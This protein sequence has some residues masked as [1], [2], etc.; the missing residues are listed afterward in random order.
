MSALCP[1]CQRPY[2]R[3]RT[4]IPETF[5]LPYSKLM[6]TEKRVVVAMFKDHLLGNQGRGEFG[7]WRMIVPLKRGERDPRQAE[8]AESS[9]LNFRQVSNAMRRLVACGWVQRVRVGRYRLTPWAVEQLRAQRIT[10]RTRL[11]KIQSSRAQVQAR[12]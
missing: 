8:L 12:R 5:E 11:D 6:W 7:E 2:P 4:P 3:L 9:W 10:L 1:T